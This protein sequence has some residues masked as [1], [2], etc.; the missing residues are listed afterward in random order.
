MMENL[1]QHLSKMQEQLNTLKLRCQTQQIMI[2]KLSREKQEL[3]DA[4]KLIKKDLIKIY[5]NIME[6]MSSYKSILGNSILESTIDD[7]MTLIM[8]IETGD[9]KDE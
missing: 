1:S 7:M 5:E 3:L 4:N 8:T 9:N 2:R 6:K